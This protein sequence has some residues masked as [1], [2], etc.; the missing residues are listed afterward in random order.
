MS[1]LPNAP[2]VEPLSEVSWRRIE[3]RVFD[4]L[5][6]TPHH[7]SA[8]EPAGEPAWWRAWR[9]RPA[10][11]IGGA[12]AVAAAVLLLMLRGA[13][14]EPSWQRIKTQAS[15]VEVRLERA[16]LEVDPWTDLSVRS[17]GEEGVQVF[18]DEGG[19]DFDVT[20]SAQRPP[21]TVV[22]GAVRVQVVG[23][24]FLVE[25]RDG[26]IG[27]EV[28]Q[29]TVYVF[30]DETREV[31]KA[32]RRWSLP[33]GN[34]GLSVGNT[35]GRQGARAAVLPGQPSKAAVQQSDQDLYEKAA[36]LEASNPDAAAAIYRELAKGNGP[37]AANA[38]FAHGRLELERGHRE[39]AVELLQ[40]YLREYPQGPNAPDARLLLQ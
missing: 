17:G 15:A 31:L 27:V 4:E 5:A 23:T 8:G 29:G 12:V 33:A 40:T 14:D 36:G 32:G 10:L 7:E 26:V 25:R 20:P 18:L 3:Q 22:A 24:R 35:H 34:A 6:R 19:V 1:N 39:A 9:W 38:L 2:E 30:H 37:W 11:A 28:T 16:T 13:G 21:F